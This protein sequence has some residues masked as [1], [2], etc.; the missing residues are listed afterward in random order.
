MISVFKTQVKCHKTDLVFREIIQ[1][2]N[3]N[4]NSSQKKKEYFQ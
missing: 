2:K 3:Y 4:Q 1:N